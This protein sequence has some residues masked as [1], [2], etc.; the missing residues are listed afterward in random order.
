MPKATPTDGDSVLT[1]S[2]VYTTPYSAVIRDDVVMGVSRYFL[3]RWLPA[4][5]PDV[6]TVINTLRQLDFRC[7]GE[8]ITISGEA[9][10]RE[11][12]MSRRHLYD[13]L[14][15]PALA[16][17]VRV[18]TGQRR[19]A[20]DG[21]IAQL[22]NRYHVRM[23]DPL[24]PVDAEHLFALLPSLAAAP[25]DAARAALD[26]DPRQLWAADPQAAAPHFAPTRAWTAL[27]VLR[28]AFPDWRAGRTQQQELAR[29][30]EALHRHITLVRDDGRASKVIVPQYFRRRWWARL[31]HELAWVYLWLRGMVY[32][33]PAEGQRRDTCWVASLSTLLTLIGRPRE[34]WRRNVEH[35]RPSGEGWSLS[36]FFEQVD[37][38]KGRDPAHPQWVARQFRVA[39]QIPVAPEDCAQYALLLRNWPAQGIAIE[40]VAAAEAQPAGSATSV[41]TGSPEV[42]HIDAH[43][44][45]EGVPQSDTPV[46]TGSATSAH[47]GDQ[48]VCHIRAQG[49]ATSAHRDSESS[50]KA[51]PDQ[52]QALS[53]SSKHPTPLPNFL[54][55]PGQGNTTADGAA[56]A[57]H[58][59]KGKESGI[60]SSATG[61]ARRHLEDYLRDAWQTRPDTPLCHAAPPE[62][63]LRD[64]WPTPIQPYSP[65]WQG[66]QSH[67][68]T[69]RDL[70]AL[71]LATWADQSV[72]HPPRYLSWLIQRWQSAPD[73]PPVSHWERWQHLAQL[74]L[75]DWPREGRAEWRKLATRTPDLLPLGL[76][77]VL[78]RASVSSADGSRE[79]S[80]R[81]EPPG[82]GLDV[83][84]INCTFTIRNIWYLVQGQLAT[85]LSRS[86]YEACVKGAE[87]V[88]YAGGVLTVQARHERARDM[89]ARQYGAQIA[90][91]TSTLAR[92]P[93]TVRFTASDEAGD[94]PAVGEL[95][96]QRLA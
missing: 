82:E 60:S 92:Q 3:E 39:L 44:Q 46:T 28:R 76:D 73:T 29:L 59:G 21:T 81:A 42:R 47:T 91:L 34:W 94:E 36:D 30:A 62:I 15:A 10:A 96:T 16:A 17:F 58:N 26:R 72:E 64:T 19:Q 88:S 57:S 45:E 54:Q 51:Q 23:D 7:K 12:A 48:G 24:T 83:V 84:P 90:H 80:R 2:K 35:A 71:I 85:Q 77:R 49:S 87:A 38:R 43:R 52:P 25:L 40:P 68:I 86:D 56:A 9:L 33:N 18:E 13:C 4:L 61:D 79:A 41:H 50:D 1:L 11:A 65:A 78:A 31:G 75:R 93:I 37:A 67:S 63:W 70:L 53:S 69:P 32:D 27:D 8:V 66:V 89:L 6:A 20:P 22:P 55:P 14:A 95:P 74:P 5:G